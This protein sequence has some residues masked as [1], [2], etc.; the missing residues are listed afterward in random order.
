MAGSFYD[1][2]FLIQVLFA[3]KQLQSFLLQYN[4]PLNTRQ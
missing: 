4:V 1:L 3:A 2:D